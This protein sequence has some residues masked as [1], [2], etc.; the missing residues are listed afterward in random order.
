V[1]AD[2]RKLYSY[3]RFQAG[4]VEG[5]ESLKGFNEEVV[6]VNK[7]FARAYGVRKKSCV[8]D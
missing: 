3:E 1:K 2:T 5:P 6:H 4:V 8:G 7:E